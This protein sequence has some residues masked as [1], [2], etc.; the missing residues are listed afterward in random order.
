MEKEALTA[1][2]MVLLLGPNKPW[3]EE[4]VTAME[5][6]VKGGGRLM[7]CS[8]D[9]RNPIFVNVLLQPY[10]IAFGSQSVNCKTLESGDFSI[11][12]IGISGDQPLKSDKVWGYSNIG[13][14]AHDASEVLLALREPSLPKVDSLVT[15]PV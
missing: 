4:E 2:D 7:V 9:G 12:R 14:E 1:F 15:R 13:I 6:Y 8:T 10:G 11:D 3:G 5:E